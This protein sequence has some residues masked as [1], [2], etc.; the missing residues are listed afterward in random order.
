M[1][2]ANPFQAPQ[3]TEPGP[4]GRTGSTFAPCPSCGKSEANQLTFTWW[5][6]VIGAKLLTHV[7]C[8]GCRTRYNGKTGKSNNTA[9]A[10]YIVVINVV[11]LGIII[12]LNA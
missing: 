5:G 7:E 2:Q 1:A 3:T 8:V 9:I 12:A 4:P 6:G 11:V 10:I